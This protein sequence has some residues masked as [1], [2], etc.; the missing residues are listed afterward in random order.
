VKGTNGKQSGVGA[1]LPILVVISLL[2]KTINLL[3]GD[4]YIYVRSRTSQFLGCLHFDAELTPVVEIDYE[5]W[6]SNPLS[7]STGYD[8]LIWK[9]MCTEQYMERVRVLFRVRNFLDQDLPE[10]ALL[11]SLQQ[12]SNYV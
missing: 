5:V 6:R 2:H 8:S 12:V 10:R 1:K 3:F 9:L 11:P 7:L 4:R